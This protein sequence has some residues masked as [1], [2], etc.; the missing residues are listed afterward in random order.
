[1]TINNFESLQIQL[2]KVTN[3]H[4][5]V[6]QLKFII[7]DTLRDITF[8]EFCKL[9]SDTKYSKNVLLFCDILGKIPFPFYWECSAI[10]AMF[11]PMQIFIVKANDFNM[12]KADITAF[13]NQ[14]T[15]LNKNDLVLLFPSLTGTSELIIP[16][17]QKT[18]P[19]NLAT[20]FTHIRNFMRYADDKMRLVFWFTC[21]NAA[22]IYLKKYGIVY[23]KTHGH[24][25]NY[26]HFRLQKTN[27]YYVFAK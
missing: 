15:T 18:K 17:P 11:D 10:K 26:F 4:N 8:S 1:M 27:I 21:A 20:K 5:V 13:A 19:L 12:R 9:C 2:I 14:I 22:Q 25:I 7:H 3:N 23:L 24:G 6:Y 16:N